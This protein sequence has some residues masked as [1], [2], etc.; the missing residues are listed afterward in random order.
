MRILKILLISTALTAFGVGAAVAATVPVATTPET[1]VKPKPKKVV[2]KAVVKKTV[3]KKTAKKKVV[4]VAKKKPA[5]DT[6]KAPG[7]SD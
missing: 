2:K 7:S 6:E 3:V 5:P 1:G 4:V